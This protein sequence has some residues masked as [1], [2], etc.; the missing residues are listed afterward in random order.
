M[1]ERARRTRNGRAGIGAG[2]EPGPGRGGRGVRSRRGPGRGFRLPRAEPP[3]GPAAGRTAA[4]GCHRPDRDPATAPGSGPGPGR[5]F[6]PP[7]A[8][9]PSGPAA[10]RT[11]AFGRRGPDRDPATGRGRRPRPPQ[12]RPESTTGHRPGSSSWATA[13]PARV[14]A[15]NTPGQGPQSPQDVPPSGTA[16]SP[17]RVHDCHRPGPVRHRQGSA[18]GAAAQA[19]PGST[20]ATRPA[21]FTAPTG[22]AK[23]PGRTRTKPRP[24]TDADE[25]G[26]RA[27][28]PAPAPPLPRSCGCQPARKSRAIDSAARSSSGPACAIE[29]AGSGSRSARA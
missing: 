20:T 23:F 21:K 17:V 28:S 1:T 18:S 29:T 2:R 22:R 16:A 12:A 7:Q 11:G 6:R 14:Y 10:G 24:G 3:S 15:R 13:S 19:R 4:F 25:G 8:V 27:S 5:G 9:P 26:G